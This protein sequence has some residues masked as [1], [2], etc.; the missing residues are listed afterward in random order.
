MWHI[1]WQD[2]SIDGL[3]A[4]VGKLAELVGK[5]LIGRKG[6]CV[7]RG[8]GEDDDALTIGSE[9]GGKGRRQAG[10]YSLDIADVFGQVQIRHT[11]RDDS[12]EC[13]KMEG[14]CVVLAKLCTGI[15]PGERML[16]KV[17]FDIAT[18]LNDMAAVPT[19]VPGLC[20]GLN[21]FDKRVCRTQCYVRTFFEGTLLSLW[22]LLIDIDNGKFHVLLRYVGGPHAR[23]MGMSIAIPVN[24]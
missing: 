15:Y 2:G 1:D 8:E 14:S 22:G 16:A 5:G 9:E 10:G 13:L 21:L 6:A 7:G 12:R 3:D 24:W 17:E 11:E 19:Y 4:L 23:G 20:V 18:M